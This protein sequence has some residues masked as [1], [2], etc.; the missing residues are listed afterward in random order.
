MEGVR[1]LEEVA[2]ETGQWE[3]VRAHVVQSLEQNGHTGVLIEIALDEKDISRALEL[4]SRGRTFGWRDYRLEVARAA[5]ESHPQDAIRL[6]RQMVQQGID[7][8]SRKTYRQ[9]AEHLV[10][11]RSLYKRLGISSEWETYFEALR[12]EYARRPALQDELRKAGL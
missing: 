10:R 2:R 12:T 1:R 4:L 7:G 5:E 11:V 9:A 6:Y 8:R 3:D